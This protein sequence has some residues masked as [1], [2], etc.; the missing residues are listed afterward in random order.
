MSIVYVQR[1]RNRLTAKIMRVKKINR[2]INE[3]GGF[4]TDRDIVTHKI[5][6]GPL[7]AK[8]GATRRRKKNMVI[9]RIVVANGL[10]GRGG[11]T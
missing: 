4:P 6:A 10:E 3:G 1:T 7:K 11:E 9:A 8:I 2:M 5:P